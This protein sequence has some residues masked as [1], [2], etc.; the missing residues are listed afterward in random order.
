[1]WTI[2]KR[3]QWYCFVLLTIIVSGCSRQVSKAKHLELAAK[4]EAQ[5][6][7]ARAILELKNATRIAPADPECH[8]QLALAYLMADNA[9]MAVGEFNKTLEINPKHVGARSKVAEMMAAATEKEVLEAA[10]KWAQNVLTESPKEMTAMNA[11]ALSEWK[12]GNKE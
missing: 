3:R 12:L 9:P 10:K 7:F 1:M 4:Y 8:Y 11:L 6:D 2:P 5:K